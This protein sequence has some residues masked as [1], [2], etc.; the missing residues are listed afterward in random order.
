MKKIQL[1]LIKDNSTDIIVK[2]G[3]VGQLQSMLPDNAD[4]FI[5]TDQNIYN[6]YSELIEEQFKDYKYNI[7]LCPNGEDAKDFD[8]IRKIYSDLIEFLFLKN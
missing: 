5:L 2:K 1:R 4:F 7:I 3:I 6:Y 8:Y